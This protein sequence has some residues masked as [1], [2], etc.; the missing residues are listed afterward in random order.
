M[1]TKKTTIGI[2]GFMGRALVGLLAGL[3]C[4]FN[5]GSEMVD[6]IGI[7]PIYDDEE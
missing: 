1:K 7:L 3:V 6:G 2:W 4:G 5:F